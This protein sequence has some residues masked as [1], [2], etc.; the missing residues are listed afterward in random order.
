MRTHYDIMINRQVKLTRNTFYISNLRDPLFHQ[1]SNGI[2]NELFISL[3]SRC[4]HFPLFSTCTILKYT[5]PLI[6]L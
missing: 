5:P 4:T 2:Y 3:I 6:L 1:K